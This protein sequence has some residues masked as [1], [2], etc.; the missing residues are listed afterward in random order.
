MPDVYLYE[1]AANPEDVILREAGETVG[2]PAVGYQYSDG[3]ISV[4]VAG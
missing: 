4:Q 1:G 2:P 3:L